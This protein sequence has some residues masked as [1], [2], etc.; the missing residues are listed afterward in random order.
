MRWEQPCL[1]GEEQPV[2][3]MERRTSCYH[4]AWAAIRPNGMIQFWDMVTAMWKRESV[5]YPPTERLNRGGWPP[6]KGR[7]NSSFRAQYIVSLLR[8]AW[9]VCCKVF[10][11]CYCGSRHSLSYF[12]FLCLTKAD[13]NFQRK[14]LKTLYSILFTVAEVVSRTILYHF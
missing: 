4:N 1:A 11:C 3:D 9:R 2:G 8:E 14:V 13:C 10:R 6:V 7:K 12:G 5:T